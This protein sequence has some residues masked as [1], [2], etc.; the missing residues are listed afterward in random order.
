MR[1]PTRWAPDGHPTKAILLGSGQCASTGRG[2]PRL[3]L[4]RSGA[5]GVKGWELA[6]GA[7]PRWG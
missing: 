3:V 2:S 5:D 7:R 1:L 6:G 4:V